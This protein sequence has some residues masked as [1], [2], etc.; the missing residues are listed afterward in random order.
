MSLP[1]SQIHEPPHSLHSHAARVRDHGL[2]ARVS[3]A[4]E[5]MAE[6]LLQIVVGQHVVRHLRLPC[7]T[8]GRTPAIPALMPE[9][10][11]L[12]DRCAPALLA[13]IPSRAMLTDRR[14]PALLASI[15]EPAMLADRRAPAIPALI[16]SPAML[17]DR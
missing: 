11:M 3:A 15:P 2:Q 14:A 4:L 7:L 10:A 9:P 16:P 8:D 5:H 6:C 12:T 13:L 17:T 1:S